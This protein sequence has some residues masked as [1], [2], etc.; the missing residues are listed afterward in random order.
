MMYADFP[1][2]QTTERSL[3]R[4][5]LMSVDLQVAKVLNE[6]EHTVQTGRYM[7]TLVPAK[8]NGRFDQ[9]VSFE[10]RD[11]TNQ[12]LLWTKYFEHERPGYYVDAPANSLVLRWQAGS[13][14]AQ[15]LAKADPEAASRLASFRNKDGIEFLQVFNLETG[16]L[17]AQMAIDTGK[18]SFSIRDPIATGDRLVLADSQHRVLV[19]SLAGEQKGVIAGNHPEVSSEADLMT[20]HTERNHL[21]LYDLATLQPRAVYDFTMPVVFNGFSGD[22]KRMLVLTSDQ[23]VYTFDLTQATGTNSGANKQ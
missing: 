11:V 18:N 23:V 14:A 15:A 17:R 20:V 4:A 12:Q 19:Y 7:L 16:K 9:K 6:N 8:E 21:E 1:K 13:Q 22:G 3:V 5:S 2:H 10:L